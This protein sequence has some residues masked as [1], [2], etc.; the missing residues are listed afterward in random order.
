MIGGS[1]NDSYIVDNV[2][3]VVTELANGGTDT[4]NSSVTYTLADKIE[5]ENL[6]MTGSSDILGLGNSANNIISGNSGRNLLIG[7]SVAD[8]IAGGAGDDI[9]VGAGTG[10]E[11]ESVNYSFMD[12]V[13]LVFTGGYPG[14]LSDGTY[15][16]AV[17]ALAGC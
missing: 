13:M 17:D 10:F 4:V 3:D 12:R 2:G 14:L 5:V 16:F 6:N 15:G 8:L 11:Y 1:G 9:L 7:D